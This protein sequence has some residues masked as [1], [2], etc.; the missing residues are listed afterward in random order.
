MVPVR[1]RNSSLTVRL[2]GVKLRLASLKWR[3]LL[4]RLTL[5]FRPTSV[6]FALLVDS[7]VLCLCRIARGVDSR[8]RNSWLVELSWVM[9]WSVSALLTV[10]NVLL[11]RVVPL[12]SP[13]RAGLVDS[14]VLL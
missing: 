9:D 14:T 5:K 7:T 11:N 2:V 3:M 1:S 6:L 13:C 8:C 10:L 4:D 12:T